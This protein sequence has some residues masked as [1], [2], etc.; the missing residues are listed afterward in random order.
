MKRRKSFTLRI[1]F[2]ALAMAIPCAAQWQNFMSGSTGSDGALDFSSTPSGTTVTFDP[3]SYNPPLNPSGNNIFNF[4]YINIPSGVSVRLSGRN[5]TGPI[6]WLASGNVTING[7]LDL[8]GE[9]GAGPTNVPTNRTIA[10]PGAGGYAGGLGGMSGGAAPT[11]GQGPAGGA[12]G[13]VGGNGGFSGNSFLVPLVGGSGGGGSLNYASFNNTTG[14]APAG[15]FGTGGGAGG[16]A[17]L[18]ASSTS[19]ACTGSIDAYGGASGGGKQLPAAAQ[20]ATSGVPEVV[21]A[22]ST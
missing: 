11:S 13:T 1:A 9:N 20:A 6:Y 21:V 2:A 15:Y 4:T 10:Y 22:Q 17:I 5:L 16:G 18:I 3:T 12:A 8:S 19:I 7:S 14:I